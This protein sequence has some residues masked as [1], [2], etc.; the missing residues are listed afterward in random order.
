MDVI[1]DTFQND[2]SELERIRIFRWMV[3]CGNCNKLTPYISYFIG[4]QGV[5]L[6]TIGEIPKLDN[7]LLE[8]SSII[9]KKKSEY[10]GDTVVAN[11]C[12]HCGHIQEDSFILDE[13]IHNV[14]IDNIDGYLPNIL[15]NEDFPIISKIIKNGRKDE[16]YDSL[17]EEK[18]FAITDVSKLDE[19]GGHYWETDNHELA[20]EVYQYLLTLDPKHD[21][22]KSLM[23]DIYY[24]RHEYDKA[25]KFFQNSR[26]NHLL[27]ETDWLQL[28]IG[29][30][31]VKNDI[32]IRDQGY[33]E[34]WNFLTIEDSNGKYEIR[35]A[36]MEFSLKNE[37]FEAL[38]YILPLKNYITNILIMNDFKIQAC[39]HIIY[40]Y[41][42]FIPEKFIVDGYYCNLEEAE[43][44]NKNVCPL[45]IFCTKKRKYYIL[46]IKKFIGDENDYSWS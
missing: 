4:F 11:L 10:T 28:F 31:F 13:I 8:K 41:R 19:I 25:I 40:D 14:D 35:I 43:K 3:E 17:T 37:L 9:G 1:V 44:F 20:L 16:W 30:E 23:A 5:I 22:A 38:E 24:K 45:R 18:I 33:M 29:Q 26:H 42:D 36:E 27:S 39:F 7:L 34:D 12:I 6:G 21:S 46:E 2:A 15:T 32:I